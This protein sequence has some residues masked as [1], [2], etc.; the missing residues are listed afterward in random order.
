MR[1]KKTAFL[2]DFKRVKE[3][4]QKEY[5]RSAEM[6]YE[7]L[8]QFIQTEMN[9]REKVRAKHMFRELCGIEKERALT[10]FEE[11]HFEHWLMF[12]YIT[13]IG[14]RPLDLYIRAKKEK[15]PSKLVET[16]GLFMLMYLAPYRVEKLEAGTLTLLDDEQNRRKVQP[17]GEVADTEEG[18]MILARISTV[19]FE[20][21]MIGPVIRIGRGNENTVMEEINDKKGDGRKAY[22]RFMKEMGVKYLHC[23][24]SRNP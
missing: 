7:S 22:H 14:S 18:D 4:R 19:G 21:M 15:M 1:G 3:L 24:S 8:F 23:H 16:A 20:S 10:S 17:L 13:V 6:L 12:D 2:V 9:L 11:M 5:V